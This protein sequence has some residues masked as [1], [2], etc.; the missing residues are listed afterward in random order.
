M[1][2]VAVHA[3]LMTQTVA[4]RPVS[5]KDNFRGLRD[6]LNQPMLF[7]LGDEGIF[8]LIQKDLNGHNQLLSLNSRFNL[9]TSSQITAFSATQDVAGTIYVAFAANTGASSNDTIHIMAP[10][11]ASFDW[12][13]GDLTSQLLKYQA[14][15]KPES[16]P[17]VKTVNKFLLVRSIPALRLL[18]SFFE[19]T[20]NPGLHMRR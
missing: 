2:K 4:A 19:L 1:A 16:T 10:I 20:M 12:S 6:R 17:T 9:P 18:S 3:E 13:Q 11:S 15:S 7:S 14:P 5:C 8:Y